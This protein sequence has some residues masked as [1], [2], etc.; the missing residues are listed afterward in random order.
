MLTFLKAK[1]ALL[2][3][4]ALATLTVAGTAVAVAG[5]NHAGPLADASG[6]SARTSTSDSHSS[7]QHYHAQGLI[8]AVTFQSS[9]SSSG[10][11]T[12]LPNGAS[13]TILVNF[14]AQTHVEVAVDQTQQDSRGSSA[15][16]GQPGATA[17]AA[18]MSALVVGTSQANGPVM[19]TEIQ[20][21]ANGKAHQGGGG[22]ETVVIGT[23]T[24]L[25]LS[26]HT[27]VLAPSNGQAAMM[28]AFDQNTKIEDLAPA[29]SL[30]TGLDVKVTIVQRS[31]GTSYAQSIQVQG[32]GHS[33]SGG[34]GTGSGNGNG[35]GHGGDSTP[36]PIP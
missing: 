20:A 32:N 13:T 33:G 7:Q 11:I 15:A 25:S 4:G 14:N 21:N 2:V 23:I 10:Q 36:T 16:H 31:D 5:H 17:L 9:N 3:I 34:S 22:S 18:G 30:A 8:Q 12:F 27:F 19:A 24:S 6:T 29:K 28:V 1:T 35:G 26:E